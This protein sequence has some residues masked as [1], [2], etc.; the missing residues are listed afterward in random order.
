MN[1]VTITNPKNE[2]R[3]GQVW[4]TQN[5]IKNNIVMVCAMPDHEG[6]SVYSLISL[7][8]GINVSPTYSTITDLTRHLEGFDLVRSE[9]RISPKC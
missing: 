5:K 2:I 1:L 4:H 9:I 8:D 3:L 6:S 7:E